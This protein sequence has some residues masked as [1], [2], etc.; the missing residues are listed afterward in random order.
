MTIILNGDP[1]PCEPGLTVRA[2]LDSLGLAGRPV[3]VERNGAALL[4]GE[5]A[6]TPLAEGDR[7][8]VVELAA[9]G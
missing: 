3:L 7:L 5:V 2:L 9:G 1:H 8:E 4:P 6:T